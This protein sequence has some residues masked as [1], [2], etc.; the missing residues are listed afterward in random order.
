M[1]RAHQ[2]L[3]PWHEPVAPRPAATV[4]L[5]RDGAQGLEALMARRSASAAFAPGAYVFPGGTLEASDHDAARDAAGHP[6][7][8][9]LP[10]DGQHAFRAAA[11]R[12]TFE[13]LGVL[14]ATDRA[15]AGIDAQAASGLSR[16][17]PL[18]TALA[19]RGWRPAIERLCWLA[20]WVT[21]R[22]LPRRFDVRFFVAPMPAGFEPR[23]DESE[24]FEP[25]WLAPAQALA[26]HAQGRFELLLPTERTLRLLA[27]SARVAELVERCRRQPRPEP[28]CARAG[29]L[30]GQVRRYTEDEPPFGELDLVAPDGRIAHRLDWQHKRAVPLTRSVARLTAPNASM[31]TGPG[32]NTYIV[33]NARDCVV[34]DPGPHE[35]DDAHVRRLAA[36]V[37]GRL[38]AILCTHSHPDHSPGAW[39]LKRLVA[40]PVLGMR[41]APGVPPSWAFEPDAELACGDR[42]AAGECTLRAVHTPG[43]MSNH[44][45]FFLEEDGLLFSGDHVLNG[46][47]TVIDPTDG[48]MA[49]YLA[50]LARLRALPATHLLPAHGHVLA[51]AARAID[52]LIAHRLAREA[53]V[54][55]ALARRP[56]AT[57]AELVRHAYDDAPAA[58]HPVAE[59]SLRAHLAK[60][61][62]DGLAAERA[63]ERWW[64]A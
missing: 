42:V 18:W 46:S 33:G 56:G 21:D 11:V 25:R 49:D 4:V 7:A 13:E 60:L 64:P 28:S 3:H 16:A 26:E 51:P 23:A 39:R 63:G 30:G 37:D 19:A 38:R 55:E 10:D 36:L 50:S 54:R 58:L 31:M 40:A 22:D 53:K 32:T 15:G 47:T 1:P 17:Q 12:E 5:V 24:L 20:H 44:L 34:I 27:R 52:R 45:C 14:L 43:H 57:P 29:I 59:R 6:A 61:A 35:P 41:S 9:D 62:R 8:G 2:Q 48:D